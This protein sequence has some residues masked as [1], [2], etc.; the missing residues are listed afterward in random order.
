MTNSVG[1]RI[2]TNARIGFKLQVS[3]TPGFHSLYDWCYQTMWLFSGA[4]KE[5]EDETVMEMHGA[6]ALYSGV[7][8]MMHAIWTEDKDNQQDAAHRMIQIAK[9]WMT[10][11]WSESKITKGKPLV[12]I[13]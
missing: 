9:P 8:S 3:A 12:W 6:N 2:A 5:P 4:P 13:P 10:R 7:K 11:R 1:W